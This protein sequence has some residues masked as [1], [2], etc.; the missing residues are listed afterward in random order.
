VQWLAT[1]E[2]EALPSDLAAHARLSA[3]LGSD[4]SLADLEGVMAFSEAQGETPESPLDAGIGLQRLVAAGIVVRHRNDRFSFRNGLLREATYKVVPEERKRRVHALAFRYFQQDRTSTEAERLPHI[5][6]HASRSG[7][8]E[9]AATAYAT[10]A[11]RAKSR[12]AYLEAELLYHEAAAHLD[13]TDDTRLMGIAHGRGLMRLRLG[14]HEDSRKDLEEAIAR[15]QRMG[16]VN[17]EVDTRLDL[18]T[19]LDWMYEF[20]RSK[21]LVD[22]ATAL[23]PQALDNLMGARL[24]MSQG[25]SK[26]RSGDIDEGCQIL[27]QAA[28]QSDALGESGYE[29]GVISRLFVGC[30]IAQQG[31]IAEAEK[32]FDRLLQDCEAHQDLMHMAA[33]LNNRYGLW[34][35]KND[36]QSIILDFRRTLAISRESGSALAEVDA[37]AN[38]AEIEYIGGNVAEAEALCR[39]SIALRRRVGQC[40]RSILMSSLLLARI[41][42]FNGALSEAAGLVAEIKDAQTEARIRG[43]REVDFVTSDQ[44]L[45]QMVV[46][47]TRQASQQEWRDLLGWS[48][49][50]SVQGERLEVLE[51][52]AAA[53]RRNGWDSV[54]QETFSLALSLAEEIPNVMRARLGRSA[55]G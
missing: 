25:R 5:A 8:R 10:L 20:D 13:E 2:I 39:R 3:L 32:I 4:L 36:I 37:I 38:L 35:A 26:I 51:Q 7:Q 48:E 18:A 23:S 16:D 28:S 31:Q 34:L 44:V 41:K 43:E 11:D 49:K 14:R 33:A 22:E 54:A 40:V 27:L 50:A 9:E 12:H 52:C 21:T 29:T 19:V 24:L 30:L 55:S 53:A 45:F 1:R 47:A 6:F 46:L 15:A 42:L 17:T